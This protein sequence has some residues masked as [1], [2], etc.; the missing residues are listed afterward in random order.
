MRVYNIT[1]ANVVATLN[2]TAGSQTVTST[3]MTNAS[4]AAGDFLRFDC[5]QIG[6]GTAGGGVTVQLDGTE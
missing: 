3:S 2:I 5:T 4:L 6:S 1:Q